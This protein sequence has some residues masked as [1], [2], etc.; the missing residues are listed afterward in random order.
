M[1]FRRNKNDISIE[2]KENHLTYS[3]KDETTNQTKKVPI[4]FNPN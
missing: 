1:V 4:Y 3:L 2:L